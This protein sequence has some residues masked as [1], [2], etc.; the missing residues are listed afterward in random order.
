MSTFIDRLHQSHNLCPG[1]PSPKVINRFFQDILGLMFPEH[2]NE[3]LKERGNL[4]MKYFD[5]QVQL[6]KILMRNSQLHSGDGEDLAIKFFDSME[7][8][9]DLLLEDLEAIY[10][11]DPAAKSKTEI[12]RC[13]P[14]FYAVAAYRVAH[15]LHSLGVFLIPRMI[16][17][18]AH[19]RT[20]V[21][22]HP[23]ARIGRHFCI[24]HG[25]GIVIGETSV[26]GDHV[27]IYQGV[28][29][30]ALSVNKEDA[31]KK[32]HPTIE[33]QVVIYAGATILG[34]DTVIGRESIVG[35]NVWL[36]KSI[37]PKSKIYYQTKLYDASSNLTDLYVLKR[38]D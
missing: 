35:G 28:T 21:E 27:K 38:D 37:P 33:D 30:G 15:L 17:E 32:R 9:Y 16:A 12:I 11:G 2:A 19:S 26:V 20:G 25:T 22:I 23:G 14:G 34:G 7:H 31:D 10:A 24:D 6:K 4:E 3:L 18:Y 8:V 13:Y 5:L 29:L 1:C 36:T